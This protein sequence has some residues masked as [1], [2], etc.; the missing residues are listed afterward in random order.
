MT[1]LPDGFKAVILDLDGLLVQTEILWSRA[2]EILFERYG[3]EYR[4]EDHIAVF[5]T[6][7]E[8]TARVFAR[9]L[10]LPPGSEDDIRREYLEV[11]AGLFEQGVPATPGAREL[12]ER[13]RGRVPLGLCSNTRRALVMRILDGFAEAG[14]FD[15]IVTGDDGAPKPAPDLYLLACRRLGVEPGDAVALEDSPT[16][17]AA[18]RAAGLTVIGVP[19]A[20]DAP[21]EGAHTVV[22]SLLELLPAAGAASVAGAASGVEAA[23]IAGAATDAE[24]GTMAA[25]GPAAIVG[26]LGMN[27]PPA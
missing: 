1:A 11:A 17:V 20:P 8:Y 22:G 19:S 2:K 6:S 3:V 4:R 25:G 13:L 5:G 10:G 7:D 9:R 12:L 27:G 18:A 16:G 15:A 23:S 14:V 21:L 24:A 26:R